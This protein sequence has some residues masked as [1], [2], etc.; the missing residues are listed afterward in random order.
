MGTPISQLPAAAAVTGVEQVPLVQNSAT[1][2]GTLSVIISQLFAISGGSALI[3]FIQSGTGA[4]LRTVQSKLRDQVNVLDFGADPTG[5]LDATAAF[6]NAI[7]ALPNGGVVNIIGT[8]S[9]LGTIAAQNNITLRGVYGSPPIYV[10]GGSSTLP[11][12]YNVAPTSVLVM[13]TSGTLTLGFSCSLDGLILFS[14]A[15]YTNGSTLTFTGT[16]VSVTG[17]SGVSV[18]DVGIK[19]CGIFG[20]NTAVNTTYLNRLRMTD[21]N[22]DCL[23]G[24]VLDRSFDTSYLNR[25]KLWQFLNYYRGNYAN[26]TRAGIAFSLTNCTG[27]WHQIVGCAAVGWATGVNDANCGA[28][29]YRGCQFDIYGSGSRNTGT[30]AFNIS[31]AINGS[32]TLIESCQATT[33]N[34]FTVNVTGSSAAFPGVIIDN[35]SAWTGVSNTGTTIFNITGGYVQAHRVMAEQYVS[36]GTVG[37]GQLSQFESVLGSHGPAII[38]I[39]TGALSNMGDSAQNLV[40][41]GFNALQSITSGTSNVGMGTNALTALTTGSNGTALGHSALSQATGSSNTAV[42]ATA[43]NGVITGT[44]CTFVGSNTQP[45]ASSDT[46]ETVLG[47]N[48]SGKGSNTAFISGTSGAYNGANTTTW[49]TTSDERIKENVVGLSDNLIMICALRPVSYRYK[50]EQTSDVGF[51]AQEYV[52]VLPEQVRKRPPSVEEMALVPDELLVIQQNLVP[53]LVG[54]IQELEAKVRQLEKGVTS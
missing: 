25:V 32:P 42:G 11:S 41:V 34:L 51:L 53:Y 52:K 33:D 35:F 17:N 50:L 13:G 10:P 43:G 36:V 6:N 39:G 46:N 31:G 30:I 47:F 5:V 7:A 38:G 1:V 44:G 28:N 16:A 14:S 27:S 19:N 45:N 21:V 15:T 40:A 18:E 3:G 8:F 9:I 22:I 37:T 48:V 12:P 24:V 26:A 4:V 20:F 23:N 29:V 2:R 49:A 54:A